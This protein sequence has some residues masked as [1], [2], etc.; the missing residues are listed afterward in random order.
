MASPNSPQEP[1][2]VTSFSS[3]DIRLI[4]PRDL[5]CKAHYR[6]AMACKPMTKAQ[7][8]AEALEPSYDRSQ[9]L[10]IENDFAW[11]YVMSAFDSE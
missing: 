11:N 3:N 10:S 6:S 9:L 8:E 1:E 4:V 2:D 7:L 5:S